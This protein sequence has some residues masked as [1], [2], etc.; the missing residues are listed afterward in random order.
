MSYTAII[1]RPIPDSEDCELVETRIF[2][3]PEECDAYVD[4]LGKLEYADWYGN[5]LIVILEA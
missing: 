2:S 5:Q 1:E 3:T 4:T